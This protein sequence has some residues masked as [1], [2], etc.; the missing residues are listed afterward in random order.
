M[1]YK[2]SIYSDNGLMLNRQQAIIPEPMMNK[3]YGII[4]PQVVNDSLVT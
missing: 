2:I 4:R 1:D 3:K